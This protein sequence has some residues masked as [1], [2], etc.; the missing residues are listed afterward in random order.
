MYY[1]V[2]ISGAISPTLPPKRLFFMC[3]RIAVAAFG[4]NIACRLC[5]LHLF[6]LFKSLIYASSLFT[7]CAV[8]HFRCIAFIPHPLECVKMSVAKLNFFLQL[9]WCCY[10]RLLLL[11]TSF[12]FHSQSRGWCWKGEIE[13]E[14]KLDFKMRKRFL[15][16]ENFREI[17][18]KIGI[19]IKF[20][21]KPYIN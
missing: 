11:A 4:W 5:T 6:A 17:E 8:P 2:I 9:L 19:N 15:R 7:I 13:E 10:F 14:E 21:K 3:E 12:L 16:F 20:N 18:V 1:G